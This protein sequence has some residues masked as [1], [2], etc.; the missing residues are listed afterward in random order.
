MNGFRLRVANIIEEGKIGGPQLR[1]T[2]VANAIS[3]SVET[4]VVMPYENSLAFRELCNSLNINYKSFWMS[5]ITKEPIVAIRYAF[6]F[7]YEVIRLAIYFKKEKFDLIHISGGSWQFKGVLAGKLA[8]IKVLWHLNDTYVPG[9]IRFFF[10]YFSYL[11]TGFIFASNRSLDY[12]QK[13]IPKERSFFVIPAP[14]ET[15][16]FDPQ[17][18]FV[19]DQELIDSLNG[20]LVIGTIANI[21]PIKGLDLLIDVASY[22]SDMNLDVVFLVVGPVYNNQKNYYN[23]LQSSIQDKKLNNVKFIDG[24][25][26][27]RYLLKHFDIYICTSLAESSPMSVWEALSMAKPVVSTDV[28]DVS[29]YVKNGYNGYIVGSRDVHI[30][31][32]CLQSLVDSEEKR[33]NYG[34]RS[35]EVAIQNLDISICADNHKNAYNSFFV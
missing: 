4:T 20:K 5:R 2:K 13:L 19:G 23:H 29:L 18:T 22:L 10:R 15:K 6:F 27:I 25:N 33:L 3:D 30:F 26:D 35:R 32:S 11:S 28:G 17:H 14:V 24:Q 7:P 9:F 8:G 12:Y 1:L 16:K 31:S 34:C 21:S